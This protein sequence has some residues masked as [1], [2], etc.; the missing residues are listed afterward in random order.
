M[1]K[2]FT[3]LKEELASLNK[4]IIAFH[5]LQHITTE[6]VMQGFKMA[7]KFMHKQLESAAKDV[8]EN[9]DNMLTVGMYGKDKD[10]LTGDQINELKLVRVEIDTLLES[11]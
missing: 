9:I 7:N 3:E 5:D 2:D 1:S 6:E 11:I 8:A 4:L 10:H